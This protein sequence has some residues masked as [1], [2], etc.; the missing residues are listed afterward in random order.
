MI[1]L[2]IWH[3]FSDIMHIKVNNGRKLANF[4]LFLNNGKWSSYL[5]RFARYQQ[6]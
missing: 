5:A 3:C 2:A 4:H 6:Y 1:N